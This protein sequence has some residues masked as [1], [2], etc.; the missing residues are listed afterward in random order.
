MSVSPPS[1][2]Q[3]SAARHR[4]A[5]KPVM[6]QAW[7]DLLFLHWTWDAA[8]I[9]S[10]LPPGLHADTF[11]G[12]AWIGVVPFWMDAVRPRGLPPVPTLSWFQELNL[13]TY[14]YDDRGEP[15]VWFYSLDCNQPIATLIARTCFHLNY[16]HARQSGCRARPGHPTDFYSLRQATQGESEFRYQGNGTAFHAAPDSLEF[17]LGERYRLFS[18]SPSG[19]RSGRVWHQ[20]YTFQPAQVETAQTALWVDQGFNPPNRPADHT[21]ISPGVDVSIYPLRP[22][23]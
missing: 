19:L 7:H 9:Q 16:Q 17:F 2:A 20:P 5:G 11:N 13:R 18:S 22:N 14:V 23:L 3:R 8:E 21:M 4:P 12:H 6:Y 10:T 15:G 1:P